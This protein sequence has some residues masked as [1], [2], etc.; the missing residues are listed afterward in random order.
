MNS[1]EQNIRERN[2]GFKVVHLWPITKNINAKYLFDADDDD[3]TYPVFYITLEIREK[4]IYK[5]DHSNF[6]ICAYDE[7][8]TVMIDW[9]SIED[10]LSSRTERTGTEVEQLIE[11]YGIDGEEIQKYRM[12]A[13]LGDKHA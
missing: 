10:D 4:K 13:I 11:H 5:E 2:D 3:N 12:V 1:A 6:L 7:T 8:G 9:F